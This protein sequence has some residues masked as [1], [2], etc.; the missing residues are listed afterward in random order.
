MEQYLVGIALN[1]SGSVCV[2]FGINIM[3]H[4]HSQDQR[5]HVEVGSINSR[6]SLAKSAA[7][8][9]AGLSMTWRRGA[10]V[11]AAGSV[12]TFCSFAY[13]SQSLL[14]SLGTLQFISNVF[15][16]RFVLCEHLSWRVVGA[17]ALIVAGVMLT[18]AFSNHSTD[19][20]TVQSLLALY[21]RDYLLFLETTGALVMSLLLTYL[22]YTHRERRKS[23][24]PLSFLV[25]P[26]AF[27]AGAATIGSQ[28]VL[29]SKCIAEIIKSSTGGDVQNSQWFVAVISLI[30]LSGLGVWLYCLNEA[31]KQFD[32][33]VIIPLLQV[34][35]CGVT[36][37]F[38]YIVTEFLTRYVGR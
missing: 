30:F 19:T 36:R 34:C 6:N 7:L 24:L 22:V 11:F 13:G 16:S 33:A 20:Y 37:I 8:T 25:R 9:V 32:G 35:W 18:V 5:M 17:T 38:I 1:V 31:L 28:S 26:L 2:N 15:F 14:A 12:M 27:S 23:P 10:A 21:D 3:K 4:S 29:Q